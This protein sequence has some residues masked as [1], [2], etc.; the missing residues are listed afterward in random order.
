MPGSVIEDEAGHDPKRIL[1]LL[2]CDCP[3][4]KRNFHSV[5]MLVCDFIP[6]AN[7]PTAEDSFSCEATEMTP[8]T[9]NSTELA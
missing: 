4:A 6:L 5:E 7:V 3:F 8:F 1:Q 2:T 9:T